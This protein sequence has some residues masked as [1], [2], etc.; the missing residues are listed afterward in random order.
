MS[1]HTGKR[2]CGQ[3]CLCVGCLKAQ[4]RRVLNSQV[5]SGADA[6]VIAENVYLFCASEGLSAVLRAGIDRDALARELQLKPE[7]KIIL[8]SICGISEEV[9]GISSLQLLVFS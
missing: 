2:G 3:S 7:Q 5:L 1:S 9:K 4:K 6:G 8:G